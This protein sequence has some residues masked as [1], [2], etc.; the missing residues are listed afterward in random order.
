MKLLIRATLLLH[1]AMKLADDI[2]AHNWARISEHED[3]NVSCHETMAFSRQI[4]VSHKSYEIGGITV[5]IKSSIRC[6]ARVWRE[7]DPSVDLLSFVEES[8]AS[9]VVSLSPLS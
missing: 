7:V 9:D 2:S 3:K 5:M 1:Y 8:C 6:A 4:L